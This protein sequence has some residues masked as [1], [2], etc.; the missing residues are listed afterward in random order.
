MLSNS[1]RYHFSLLNL[2]FESKNSN[3][4]CNYVSLRL[5]AHPIKFELNIL[6]INNEREKKK[7]EDYI[8]FEFNLDEVIR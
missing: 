3:T 5:F 8:P 7:T 6:Q 4:S 1:W 2:T